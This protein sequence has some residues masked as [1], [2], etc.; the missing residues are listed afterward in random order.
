MKTKSHVQLLTCDNICHDNKSDDPL[1]KWKIDPCFILGTTAPAVKDNAECNSD[2]NIETM[3]KV[4]PREARGNYHGLTATD[5]AD[6]A[7]K[8]ARLEFSKIM[9]MLQEDNLHE[10]TKLNG[11]DRLSIWYGDDFHIQ[12][13]IDK[14]FSIGSSGDTE[15]GKHDQTH[16][17]Q[18][19]NNMW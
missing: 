11:V 6:A 10:H 16:H 2:L 15:K 19:S 13:L 12:A 4:V 14:H 5:N 7:K 1:Q 18:V 17:R 8:E 9:L 3:Q